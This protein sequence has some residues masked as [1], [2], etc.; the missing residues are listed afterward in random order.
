MLAALATAGAPDYSGQVRSVVRP[1][2][3]TVRPS[4]DEARRCLGCGDLSLRWVLTCALDVG[5]RYDTAQSLTPRHLA[6]G[7]IVTTT[8]RGRVVTLPITP[9]LRNLL[10]LAGAREGEEDCRI[11]DLLNNRRQIQ[12]QATIR[13][14]WQ[15]WKKQAGLPPG[16]YI[17]DL[18]RDTAHRV[19][20]VTHDVRQVQA[21]LGHASPRTT[22][23][24][25]HDA[26]PKA[27]H[28]AINQATIRESK[29][30]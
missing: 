6:T 18:R 7:Q 2:P 12:G 15:R 5:L 29:C 17:H 23:E 27:D 13:E 24:Y 30:A 16:L 21:V 20:A 9:R 4:E 28:E 19:Y 22:L 26:A 10:D 3:R 1:Q 8:K 11:T 14:R 25:L